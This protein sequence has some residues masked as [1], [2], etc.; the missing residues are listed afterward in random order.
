MVGVY[1]EGGRKS[2]CELVGEI[3]YLCSH[4]IL[5]S[6]LSGGCLI[7]WLVSLVDMSDFW[8]EGII[9]VGIG[10][11]RTDGKQDLGDGEGWRPLF[12]KDIQAN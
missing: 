5:S 9:W 2:A 1:H 11:Q 8:H 7:F 6:P 10:Q 3:D 4:G 12:L